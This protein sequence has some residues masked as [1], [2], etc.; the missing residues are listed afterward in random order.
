MLSRHVLKDWVL[1]ALR[2]LGKPSKIVDVS[3]EIWRAHGDDLAGT[4]LFY[5]WQ[6]D[7]RWAALSLS[8]ED[9]VLLSNKVGR[10]CWA[11]G[12]KGIAQ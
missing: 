9:K 4:P 12:P 6:Y 5:T 11:L 3:K 7:M 10:G 8:K 1:D 2:R